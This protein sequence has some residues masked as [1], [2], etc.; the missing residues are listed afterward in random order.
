MGA[1]VPS[2]LFALFAIFVAA[3]YF[4]RRYNKAHPEAE[5]TPAQG[6]RH[7]IIG[8]TLFGIA[9]AIW[10]YVILHADRFTP[11]WALTLCVGFGGFLLGE[12][13]GRRNAL[14]QLEGD[15]PSSTDPA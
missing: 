11:S 3:L 1:L 9:L 12:W 8:L 2:P 5:L 4:R 15:R 10:I 6:L 13:V 14:R 7:K